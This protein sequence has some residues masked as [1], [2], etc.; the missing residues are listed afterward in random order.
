MFRSDYYSSEDDDFKLP[1]EGEGASLLCSSAELGRRQGSSRSAS[2][3]EILLRLDEPCAVVNAS[4]NAS[5]V[6]DEGDTT[7]EIFLTE[8]YV[9]NATA[10][11]YVGGYSSDWSKLVA[12]GV[13]LLEED[14]ESVV[15]KE[16][17]GAYLSLNATSDLVVDLSAAA[18]PLIAVVNLTE[19]FPGKL[20]MRNG[21]R[22]AQKLLG[23]LM[24][25]VFYQS[26]ASRQCLL[27]F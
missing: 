16:V 11:E 2:R 9:N 14:G 25:R 22:R 27:P 23:V 19:S 5:S 17:E 26:V 13:L 1:E 15:R 4:S 12:A 10:V 3:R 6:A 18:N 7:D 8:E 24:R 21:R 20:G